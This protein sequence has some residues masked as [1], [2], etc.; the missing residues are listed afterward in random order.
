MAIS[1]A[2]KTG[3]AF[4][5]TVGVGYAACTVIFWLWPDTSFGFMNG[6]FHGLDFRKLQ[7]GPALFEFGSFAIALV[8]LVGWAFVLGTI[9]GWLRGRLGNES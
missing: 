6:L 5:V 7:S 1:N 4:A 2:V 9:F 8:V 3:T